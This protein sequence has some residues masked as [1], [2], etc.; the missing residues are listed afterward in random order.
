MYVKFHYLYSYYDGYNFPK[1]FSRHETR[2]LKCII[3]IRIKREIHLA[4]KRYIICLNI[5]MA[6]IDELF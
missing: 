3:V 4:F 2:K 6:I 1:S 5:K